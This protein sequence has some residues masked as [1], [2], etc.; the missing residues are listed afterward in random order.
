MTNTDI[1]WA[2]GLFEGEGTWIVRP[3]KGNGNATAVVALQM[4][5]RDVVERF[6]S[7][8]GCGKITCERRSERNP[9]HSDMWRWTTAKRADVRRIT[10]LLVPYLGQRRAERA[11][12]VLVAASCVDLRGDRSRYN[13]PHVRAR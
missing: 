6:A 4:R 11:R 2:A 8:M 7:I 12:D 3:P 10:E 1:A 9:K 13:L 5:D